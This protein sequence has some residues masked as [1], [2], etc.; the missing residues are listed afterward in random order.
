MNFNTFLIKINRF[1][2]WAL[3][4]LMIL[5]FIS[6]YGMTKEIINPVTAKY[7]HEVL[8]PIP[9]FVFFII[10]VGLS[11]RLALIRWHL[12][13]QKW[14]NFYILLL[15]CFFLIFFLWLYFT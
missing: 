6:G 5:Y 1:S 8:L 9:M 4:V 12:A 15:S 3:L 2:G 14:I 10:H 13:S 7:L 11:V